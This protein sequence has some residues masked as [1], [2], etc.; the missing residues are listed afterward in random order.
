MKRLLWKELR[1]NVRWLPIGMLVVATAC[2]IAYPQDRNSSGLLAGELLMQLA[3]VTPLLAFALGVVQSYRDLQPGPAAYL[4]HR[5]V[6]ASQIFLAKTQAGFMLYAV[7]VIVPIAILAL[8]VGANGMDWYPMR[9]A[10]VV[11]SLVFCLAAFAMHPAAMMVMSRTAIWWGTRCLPL[12]PV[13]AA[14]FLLFALLTS[15]GLWWSGVCLLLVIPVLAWIVIVSR[16][17]WVELATDPPAWRTNQQLSHR[18][19]IPAYLLIGATVSYLAA[20][21]LFAIIG[22]QFTRSNLYVPQPYQTLAMNTATSDPWLVTYLSEY[23]GETSRYHDRPIG[24]KAIIG[25]AISDSDTA[26]DSQQGAVDADHLHPFSSL[27]VTTRSTSS[28]DGFFTRPAFNIDS[29]LLTSYDERGFLLC[30]QGYPVRRWTHTI[31][32][33]GVYSP[34]DF[35]GSPFSSNPSGSSTFLLF[36][37]S[38]YTP[39]LIDSDGV[40]LVGSSPVSIT[41][42]IDQPN[43]SATVV[44]GDPGHAPR[45][46]LRHGNEIHEYQLVDETGSDTWYQEPERKDGQYNPTNYR[47]LAKLSLHA[48]RVHTFPI[49]GLIASAKNLRLGLAGSTLFMSTHHL[50]TKELY[51]VAASGEFARVSYDSQPLPIRDT[52]IDRFRW[53]FVLLGVLPGAVGVC[54]AVLATWVSVFRGDMGEGWQGLLSFPIQFTTLAGSFALVTLLAIWLTRRAANRRGLS[55]QQSIAWSVSVVMLGLIAPLSILAI[56]RRVHRTACSHCGNARRVDTESCEHCEEAWQRPVH[57]DVF[58]SD[59]ASVS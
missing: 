41:Q 21:A 51:R 29:S 37:E 32:R 49:P 6:T 20:I 28:S 45:L 48:Q 7:S 40:Y 16:Q 27:Q 12:V 52:D 57:D 34:R 59:E 17:S 30:Y 42:I 26:V 36:Q 53:S 3:I 33:D 2:W 31:A 55:R 50:Q 14:L 4:Q 56:Y 13:A 18:W 23:D 43:D 39:P 10:Q 15:G 58:L 54:V 8:W 1:E 38:G 44:R 22:E 24:A 9:P 11:P 46:L 5:G 47:Q 19:Q 25:D 35:S